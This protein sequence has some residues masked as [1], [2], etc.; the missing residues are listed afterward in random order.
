MLSLSLDPEHGLPLVDQ[1]VTA[2]RDRID[3]RLLRPGMRLPPIR[4]LAESHQI[5]RFT[6]VEAY[7]RLVALGYLQ[8]RRGSGFYVAPRPTLKSAEKGAIQVER[9]IDAAW[10]MREISNEG[11]DRVLAGAGCLSPDWLDEEGVLR[12]LRLLTRRA[13]SRVTSYGTPQGYEP[14]RNQLQIK[15]A[16][17]GIG[18]QPAQLVLTHGATQALDL[19]ARYFL[20]AGD[21]VLVDDPGYW[22]LFANL[23][24]YGVHLIG[25]RHTHDGP[26]PQALEELLK[27]H[28]PKL[29]FTQS[30]L[31]NPTSANL[32]PANAFRILQLAEKHDFMIVEDDINGDFYPGATTRL[33][34]LDQLQR[35][36]YIGSFAKT[37]SGNLRVGFVACAHDLAQ[38]LAD[39]K[40]VSFLSSAELSEH[41]V[42]LMLTGGHYRKHIERMQGRLA[43]STHTALRVLERIGLKPYAEPKGGMFIWAQVPGLQDSAAL[44]RRAVRENIVLAPGNVFRPQMQPSPW[45]RFNVAYSNDK[46]LERLFVEALK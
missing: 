44:A 24:L 34:A 9:A 46:R 7:D 11:P 23:R 31:H 37:V 33:A 4:Q 2:L 13:G 32:S 16:E 1:I 39:V 35:V 42:Y 22:N 25:V 38:A 26:D 27:E 19:V 41:L 15:L 8:S 40:I 6:V 30:V 43:D 20:R 5:S 29:F 21:C 14:L 36:I 10:L 45:L 3:D 12:N 17:F 28:K 18:A